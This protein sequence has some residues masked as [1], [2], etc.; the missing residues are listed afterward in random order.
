MAIAKSDGL[1]QFTII[2]HS[3]PFPIKRVTPQSTTSSPLPFCLLLP[4]PK[5]LRSQSN[6]KSTAL[7]S[8]SADRSLPSAPL[9]VGRRL[10][11]CS[12]AA[13]LQLLGLW[14]YSFGLGTC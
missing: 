6:F 12:I 3:I 7:A 13:G 1:R 5:S 14:P 2:Y 10:E 9:L 4:V 11:V 8:H